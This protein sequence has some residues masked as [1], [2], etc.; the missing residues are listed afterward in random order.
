MKL[1]MDFYDEDAVISAKTLLLEHVVIPDNDDKRKRRI[2][3]NKK[4][5]SMKDILNVF[6][7]L[8]L[9]DVPL[10]VANNLH[11]L[12]PLSMDNFDMS[13]VI[14]DMEALKIQ[15][16]VLQEAQETSLAAHVALC[17]EK[18]R[19]IDVGAS[20]AHSTGTP[21]SPVMAHTPLGDP[22]SAPEIEEPVAI[23]TPGGH[24][25]IDDDGGDN[26]DIRRLAEIQGRLPFTSPRQPR[27][28]RGN[29]YNRNGNGQQG[30]IQTYSAAATSNVWRGRLSSPHR[31]SSNR[32]Q[33][34]NHHS[35][36][37]RFNHSRGGGHHRQTHDGI[38]IITGTSTN[39]SLRAAP[40]R[41][42]SRQ[43]RRDGLFISRLSR[44]TRAIDVMNYIRNEAS[45]NIR[46]DPIATRYDT[47]RSYYIHAAP[48]HHALLLRPGMWPKDVLVKKFN[49]K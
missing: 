7:E 26:E 41:A 2:G 38:P 46:C 4:A 19:D 10:F 42:S 13:R 15:M 49:Q 45:L 9:E 22:P 48:G 5:T 24:R 31:D 29:N 44:N 35:N 18:S 28:R 27:D 43:S 39:S 32:Q 1:C 6:L 36:S 14:R 37:N 12:P 30:E 34:M 33:I 25:H 21:P 3:G 20:P 16:K 47:Y 8:S 17:R 23:T 40:P 11:N